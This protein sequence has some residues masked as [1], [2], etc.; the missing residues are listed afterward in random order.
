MPNLFW[1]TILFDFFY[2]NFFF[3]IF[4]PPMTVFSLN[5]WICELLTTKTQNFCSIQPYKS[6]S[7][8]IFFLS[9]FCVCISQI[10]MSDPSLKAYSYCK[11]TINADPFANGCYYDS[12]QFLTSSS[13]VIWYCCNLTGLKQ[14][15]FKMRYFNFCQAQFKFS[16]SSVQLGTEISL[17][18]SV[19]PHPP[20]PVYLSPF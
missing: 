4:D 19:T 5:Y 6:F 7:V 12:L 8:T 20:R 14:T 10:F 3:V 2:P 18:I 15:P 16:T 1:I 13:I 17:N 11:C 9:L